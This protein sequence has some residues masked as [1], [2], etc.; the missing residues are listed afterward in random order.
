M[1]EH[2]NQFYKKVEKNSARER[3]VFRNTLMCCRV[4]G[5]RI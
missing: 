3:D 1:I 4:S 2:G 5:N